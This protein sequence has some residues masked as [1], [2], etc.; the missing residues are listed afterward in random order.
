M[1]KILFSLLAL[2]N[3]FSLTSITIPDRVTSIG[4]WAFSGCNRLTSITIPKGV[5][6]ISFLAF[7][8]CSSL[9][10]VFYKGTMKDFDN[11]MILFDNEYFESATKYFY[12]EE[13]PTE[14]GNYWHYVDGVET[15]W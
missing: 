14:E 3:C 11:I 7:R 4:G 6:S 12:S 9:T 2:C 5:K 1:K 10:N 8:G 15:I 13:A